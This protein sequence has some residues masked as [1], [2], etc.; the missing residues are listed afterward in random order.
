MRNLKFPTLLTRCYHIIQRSMLV[1]R[2]RQ[3]NWDHWQ[4]NR[5]IQNKRVKY[6]R[7]WG[8][9]SQEIWSK[10]KSNTF[11]RTHTITLIHRALKLYEWDESLYFDRAKILD[12]KPKNR[13]VYQREIFGGQAKK[14]VWW[15]PW[16]QQA[17]KD[18]TS[19]EKLRWAASKLWPG[20]IRMGQPS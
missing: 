14:G 1:W 13:C 16:H 15:M 5:T 11:A 2:I 8:S 6:N 10:I 4:E 18:A 9:N 19:C 7:H 12:T 17:M 20:D 3:T